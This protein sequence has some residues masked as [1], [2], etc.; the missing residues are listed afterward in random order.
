MNT[1]KQCMCRELVRMVTGYRALKFDLTWLCKGTL[2]SKYTR[3]KTFF[4]DLVALRCESLLLNLDGGL[5]RC[6]NTVSSSHL[7]GRTTQ[8]P[9][10]IFAENVKTKLSAS[11][12]TGCDAQGELT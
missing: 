8:W 7:R 11:F 9:D 3:Y 2:A 6:K 10:L 4:I 5:N 1:I 12:S